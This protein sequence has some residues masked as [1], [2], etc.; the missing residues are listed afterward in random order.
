MNLLSYLL[1]HP[2]IICDDLPLSQKERGGTSV[3]GRW[4]VSQHK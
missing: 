1:T 2:R 4:G 3:N